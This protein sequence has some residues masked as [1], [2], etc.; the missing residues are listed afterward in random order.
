MKK[1]IIKN[2]V[3][4]ITLSHLS[5]TSVAGVWTKDDLIQRAKNESYSSKKSF[6]KLHQAR[7]NITKKVGLLLPNFNL[8]TVLNSVGGSTKTYFMPLQLVAPMIGFAFPSNWFSLK[9]SKLMYEAEKRFFVSNVANNMNSIEIMYL[10]AH[11]TQLTIFEYQK[12]INDIDKI[13][14]IVHAQN[15]TNPIPFS[16]Y[17]K[18][19][20]LQQ[21]L[22]S[23]LL[24]LNILLDTQKEEI[25][26]SLA[27]N[28]KERQEFILKLLNTLEGDNLRI[29]YPEFRQL[30]LKRS[31]ESKGGL[32]L[33][34]A[35]D[36]SIKKRKWDF[37][38]LTPEAEGGMSLGYK[39]Q[40]D[41]AK[42]EKRVLS[43]EIDEF[44]QRYISQLQDIY[45]DYKLIHD[46][47]NSSNQIL[48]NAERY[49]D[50]YIN[51]LFSTNSN[52]F[53]EFS[54]AAIERLQSKIENISL[55]HH[56]LSIEANYRR[57]LFEGNNY[58][59][60]L[61]KLWLKSPQ[62]ELSRDEKRENRKINKAIKKGQLILPETEFF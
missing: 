39:A 13:M 47:I 48:V 7:R 14:K 49:Y 50:F 36:F 54:E 8:G 24:L 35:S 56:R 5:I 57:V 22:I 1:Q 26:N 45:Q 41:I 4:I 12:I 62:D 23:D 19:E 3:T 17:V 46:L 61:P 30:A 32:F 9:E 6:E 16:S 37:I 11:K 15:D 10:E 2:F 43:L 20:I 60:L 58:R 31:I 38:S 34:L 51:K 28:E 33:L 44:N 25:G 29:T 53:K 55:L 40:I 21:K 42:S 18:L 27:L 52:E 59:N